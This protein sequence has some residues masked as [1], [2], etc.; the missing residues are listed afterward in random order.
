M[1]FLFE[2][3]SPTSSY[4]RSAFDF[5]L[6]WVRSS[7]ASSIES[8]IATL[9]SLSSQIR[10][11]L[12]TDPGNTNP[13]LAIAQ[14]IERSHLFCHPLPEPYFDQ[15]CDSQT[16]LERSQHFVRSRRASSLRGR[17]H[18]LTARLFPTFSQPPNFLCAKKPLAQFGERDVRLMKALESL[19]KG[20]SADS[21]RLAFQVVEQFLTAASWIEMPKQSP[22]P[23][24]PP[25]FSAYECL[26]NPTEPQDPV[27][28]LQIAIV[29]LIVQP[30]NLRV[31]SLVRKFA[32]VC[33]IDP[34]LIVWLVQNP[35]G[36]EMAGRGGGGGNE[37]KEGEG[38]VNDL[39]E[40]FD[41]KDDEVIREVPKVDMNSA[42]EG[43]DQEKW[44]DGDELERWRVARIC[45]AN[46]Y[47]RIDP[48]SFG[49]LPPQ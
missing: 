30:N 32:T 29:C 46:F 15:T 43:V 28:L 22:K 35:V 44:F 36:M 3:P 10:S 48:D 34:E 4:K 31:V 2:F 17:L 14:L 19:V 27:I 7:S 26:Q 18:L 33:E 42:V 38:E 23:P 5:F 39:L 1:R 16:F 6:L 8:Q 49:L 11:F 13:S 41:L 12:E 47:D 21:L 45:V 40:R 9:E 25:V 37:E 20:G 24:P